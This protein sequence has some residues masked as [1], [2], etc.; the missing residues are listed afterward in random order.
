MERLTDAARAERRLILLSAGT[1]AR[2]QAMREQALLLADTV[3]WSRLAQML[4]RRRLL[5]VLGP[6]ITALAGER[7]GDGFAATVEEALAAGRRQGAL[8]ALISMRVM[9]ALH[10]AGIRASPLKGPLLGELI[11]GDPGRRPSSD[12][13]LLVAPEQLDA[14]V[15]VVCGLGY[16]TPTDHVQRDGLPQLHFAL[17]HERDELPPVELHWRIHW[18]ER[19]F[20]AQRL[21]PPGG[22]LVTGWRPAPADELAGLLLF[23][24][25]DGFVDLRLATDVGAWWDAFGAQLA[26]E[27]LTAAARDHPQLQRVLAVASGVAEKVVGIP[28]KR[29]V[30]D[31][32]RRHLR[33]RLAMRLAN[34]NPRVS[35]PQL[36]ADIGLIDALLTPRGHF[37]EFVRRQLLPPR[38]VLVERARNRQQRSTTPLGH[39]V[40][41]VGRYGL[42]IPRMLRAPETLR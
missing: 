3:D 26:P 14:A 41:V 31:T 37:G 9:A 17:F 33:D 15:A 29:L 10:D 42:A 23:Y 8:L 6:R 39:G 11:Y 38:A 16:R 32:S 21:L 1:R 30:C 35:E 25:R 18:Y 19:G 12:I 27:A 24:A 40:R 34:P 7:C 5:T 20:A 22:D 2:R 28:A 36:Y 13:D 4:R